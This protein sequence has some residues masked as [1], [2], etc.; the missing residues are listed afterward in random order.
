MTD[1]AQ[2][3]MSLLRPFS[4][5]RAIPHILP[6]GL[7]QRQRQTARSILG[8]L[9]FPAFLLLIPSSLNTN[10]QH[11]FVRI[12]IRFQCLPKPHHSSF[13]GNSRRPE[14]TQTNR[15][16]IYLFHGDSLTQLLHYPNQ[17]NPT[18]QAGM[19]TAQVNDSWWG[20]NGSKWNGSNIT[21]PFYWL[22]SRSDEPLDGSQLPQTVFHAVRES[23]PAFITK[24]LSTHLYI[25]QRQH[26]P[27]P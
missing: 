20:D 21:Y 11:L 13:P 26:M 22:L 23:L 6:F 9:S 18:D 19:I 7:Q 1:S 10:G 8:T 3:G 14:I 12:I 15:V 5:F 17:I 4:V 2:V 25:I 24:Y 27:I 16:D